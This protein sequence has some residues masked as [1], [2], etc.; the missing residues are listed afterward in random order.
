M[1]IRRYHFLLILTGFILSLYSGYISSATQPAAKGNSILQIQIDGTINPSTVDYI[2]SAI[3]KADNEGKEALLILLDTPGGLLTST[4]DIVKEIL[5][6]P[7]PVV[8]Y[9]YP[10]GATATSAGVFITMS[11]NIAAMS[12]GTSIGAAHPV[13]IG[14][15][16]RSPGKKDGEKGENGSSANDD[17]MSEKIENYASSFIESIAEERGRNVKWA[18]EAVRKSASITANEA[19]KKNVV[20]LIS[21]DIPSLLQEIDGSK[22]NIGTEEVTLKTAGSDI[23]VLEMNLKQKIVDLISTPDIAFLLLSIGSLGILIEFYN[24]GMIFPG[25]AGLMS[26][27]IGF[28]SLQII[29]FNY[30]GLALLFLGLGLFAAEV[31]VTSYGLL[32]IGGFISFVFGAL[33]LFDTPESD[34]RVG[35]DVI[36][37]TSI[38]IGLFF[39]FVVYFIAKSFSLPAQGGFEGL[40]NQ[41]GEVISWEGNR[42]KVFVQGEY[43]DAHSD[44]PLKKGDRIKVIESEGELRIKV[45]KL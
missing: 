31:Y 26:L 20:D 32:S 19:V 44:D 2:R 12:P 29:P 1:N 14:Q 16:Q 36:I 13:S 9:V 5:N 23:E 4:Q 10:K 41:K 39:A 38:A 17:V 15:Q 28:V 40:R 37:A 8:I 22:V 21:P 25:I 33:L 27:L 3:I 11:A 34:M 24:P 45:G 35:Y 6:S 18:S 43:W 42:G 7:V 30:G